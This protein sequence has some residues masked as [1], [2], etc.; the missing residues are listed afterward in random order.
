[1]KPTG[2]KKTKTWY[3]FESIILIPRIIQ[4]NHLLIISLNLKIKLSSHIFF[5]VVKKT[6]ERLKTD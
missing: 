3:V 2:S 1:M 4:Q 5:N 6:I